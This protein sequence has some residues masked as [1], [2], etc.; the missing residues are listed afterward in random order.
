[1][2][3][4]VEGGQMRRDIPWHWMMSSFN[5]TSLEWEPFKTQTLKGKGK[6]KAKGRERKGERVQLFEG[7]LEYNS[8]LEKFQ[9]DDVVSFHASVFMGQFSCTPHLLAGHS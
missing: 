7:G 8:S 4:A 1:M 9:W 2:K 6:A 3:E 5:I